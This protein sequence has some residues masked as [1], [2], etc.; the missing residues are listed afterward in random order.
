MSTD[1]HKITGKLILTAKIKNT[2]PLL[3]ATGKGEETDLEVIKD[4][5]GIPFIP[6]A[7]FAGMLAASFKGPDLTFSDEQKKNKEYFWGSENAESKNKNLSQSHVIID[8]LKIDGSC[9]IV[10]RDGVAIS[11]MTGT[12]IEGAKYDYELIEP[13]AT[14]ILN[15][16]IT[17]RQGF[18]KASF[19]EFIGYIC[20]KGE[21]G[22]Y[23]QGAFK[24]S[25][26]G[27]LKWENIALYD[28]DFTDKNSKAAEKWF[29]YLESGK[30]S[31]SNEI[32]L[33]EEERLRIYSGIKKDV[34]TMEGEFEIKN[35]LIISTK[36]FNAAEKTPDKTHLKNKSGQPLITGKS[37]KGPIRHRALKILNT[38]R[39]QDVVKPINAKGEAEKS[40]NEIYF[41]DK[42]FGFVDENN[43]KAKA[44]RVKS[45]ETDINGAN[46][47]QVQTRIKIDRFTGGTIGSALMQ[48]QPLW[49]DDEKFTL[50]FQVEKCS[51]AEAGLLLL[52]MKDLMTED[53]PIG[54]EK[55]IG[56]GILKGKELT[57]SGM[58]EGEKTIIKFNTTGIAEE[59]KNKIDV[60]NT[61]VKNIK[62]EKYE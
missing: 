50:R 12:A 6:A 60:V 56:R 14:F 9:D 51:K 42:L 24:S 55:A 16:E 33:K 22:E 1:N 47:E 38:I 44:S 41:I 36:D 62:T 17:L 18:S 7:G 26:F 21:E 4:S 54:G 40:K 13:G 52:V 20:K 34:L 48:T 5:N 61:W 10:T 46:K 29:E 28:Y 35:S 8:D 37:L 27:M 31:E 57:V 45:F 32:T 58:V 15:A 25:G 11:I 53:L 43:K 2:S 23:Q 59:H 3:I 39:E 30:H 19:L 49:H